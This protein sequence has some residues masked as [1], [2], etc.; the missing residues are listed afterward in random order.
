[1]LDFDAYC[2]WYVVKCITQHNLWYVKDIDAFFCDLYVF[3]M[4]YIALTNVKLKT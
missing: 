4:L 2:E 1:M 3:F